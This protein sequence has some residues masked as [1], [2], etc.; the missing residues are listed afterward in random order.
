MATEE[1]VVKFPVFTLVNG[2]QLLDAEFRCAVS[3]LIPTIKTADGS[4]RAV[5]LFTDREGAEEYLHDRQLS[6]PVCVL[7]IPNVDAAV[8]FLRHLPTKETQRV[9]LDPRHGTNIRTWTLAAFLQG[10][11]DMAE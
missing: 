2:V 4:F 9:V 11:Q 1:L 5:L 8:S 3:P 10:F 7:E 6:K